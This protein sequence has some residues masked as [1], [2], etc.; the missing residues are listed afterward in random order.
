MCSLIL[1]GRRSIELHKWRNFSV[2]VKLLQNVFSAFSNPFSSAADVSLR[3]GRKGKNFTISY[4]VDSL[5]LPKKLAESISR[6]VSFEDKVNPDSVLNLLRSHGFRDS[7]I[8]TIITD[9]PTLLILDAEKSLAPKFQF[10]QS[11]GAS[12]SELTQIVSTVPEILGKRGDKTLSL[13]YDFVKES[14]VADKS[15]KLEKLCHS[16]P[17]GKQEDKI[18]NVSVLRELGMPHKLLFSLLTSVGQPVCGKDRFD[19]SLKK[20]V[21]M[22][23][24]PTTAKFVKA[25]YV[26]YNLS[27]KTIEEKVH[28]YKRLGF[29]VED[30]WVMFKKWPFSLK[31]SEEK[32]TQTI[33]TLKMC[34]L[35]ENEVLQVLKKYPQFIRM[36]QQKILNFIETFLGLAFSRDEFTMIVKCF[37]MCFGLS[38]E[39]VKKKT[40]F[41][42][43][44]INWSLK[45]ITLFPQVFGYS[46]EKRIVPRCNVIKALMSR[47]LLGSE[48]PSMASVLACTD[49]AFVKRYVRKQNDKELVAELMAIFIGKKRNFRMKSL[50]HDDKASE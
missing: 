39:T 1:H 33:E 49:H 26:V 12:S 16:L 43:K 42:V 5:G 41:V 23:F 47:G 40:E 22:G 29:A 7:Q 24:D 38:A 13:C 20:I 45:D 36:S 50:K 10:L 6:K 15:S 32:I 3:D 19:A 44:Q 11:R 37:P 8:S 31:F 4:L 14:L 18:R 27:D 28:I 46:M 17:E 34:G 30:V 48:L 21:E 2:S 25:L 35:N 9:Y